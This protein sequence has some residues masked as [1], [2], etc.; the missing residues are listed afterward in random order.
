M[1]KEIIA[2]KR[3]YATELEER[4][5]NI[6][7]ILQAAKECVAAIKS[8]WDVATQAINDCKKLADFKKLPKALRK[9]TNWVFSIASRLLRFIH[10]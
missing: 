3:A 10:N 5:G 8:A 7:T 1:A 6:E 9:P 4:P 2:K